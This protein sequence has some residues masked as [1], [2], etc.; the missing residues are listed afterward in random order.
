MIPS[1]E[2]IILTG[3][4][5]DSD[6]HDLIESCDAMIVLTRRDDCLTCGAYEALSSCK[7]GVLSDTEVLRKTFGDAFLYSKA[8][9]ED[10]LDKVLLLAD[11]VDFFYAKVIER[12]DAFE[13]YLEERISEFKQATSD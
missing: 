1:T 2:N 8:D 6:Y 12:R 3:F 13:S 10:I 7:T 4:I 11:S 5:S 9:K